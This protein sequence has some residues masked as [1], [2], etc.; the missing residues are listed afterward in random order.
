MHELAA[1]VVPLSKLARSVPHGY[2]G[3]RLLETLAARQVPFL[4]ATWFIKV[5]GLSEMVSPPKVARALSNFILLFPE[6]PKTGE[7]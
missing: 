2:K 5:V 7:Q 3:E 4:R 6:E 1:G